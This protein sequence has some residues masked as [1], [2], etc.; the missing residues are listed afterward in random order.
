MKRWDHVACAEVKVCDSKRL[1][2][3]PFRQM[4]E[5]QAFPRKP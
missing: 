1:S 4:R 2:F 3:L 5:K